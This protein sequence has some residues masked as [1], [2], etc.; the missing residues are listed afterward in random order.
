MFY[1]EHPGGW[2]GILE[3]ES[4]PP[5]GSFDTRRG[6]IP[7]FPTLLMFDEYVL[8]GEAFE[9]LKRPGHRLWLSEWS[10]LVEV[11][12]S[13]GSLTVA[14]VTGAAGARSHERGWMLRRDLVDH[15]RWSEA[16]AY[17]NTLTHRAKELLGDSPQEA[18]NLSWDFDPDGVFDVCGD[19]GELHDLSAVLQDGVQ[20]ECEAHRNLLPTAL[21]YLKDQ[22]RQ[23]N[24]CLAACDELD[25]AP[26][27]WAPYRRYLE[28]KLRLP[29]ESSSVGAQSAGHQF[30]EVAF[31]AYAPTS[32]RDFAKLRS[33][34]RISTLRA[35]V[36]RAAKRGDL[37]DPHY[38][39]RVLTEVLRLEQG[40]AHTR[41]IAG[42]VATVVG[43]IPIPGLGLAAAAV[44]QGVI[45]R[46]QRKRREP[47]H[48][49]YL[50]SDGRGAT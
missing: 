19:D 12:E 13:E 31:P 17:Y 32:V 6:F 29:P 8:D 43:G 14:D 50:I 48:W 18:Q 36:L 28:E 40:L 47:W 33:D 25:V 37:V 22:L 27:M 4:L 10:E 44:A 23:V 5:L 24:A 42:W 2:A 7:D 1:R 45:G 15:R 20:S 38:P 35:E 34:R 21:D 46:L 39:Q 16:M 26:V 30:F 9:R 49:F 3:F 41:R 11:L